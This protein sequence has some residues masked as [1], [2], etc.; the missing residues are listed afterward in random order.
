MLHCACDN[1]WQSMHPR[2]TQ[3]RAILVLPKSVFPQKKRKQ[4]MRIKIKCLNV[5]FWSSTTDGPKHI[6]SMIVDTPSHWNTTMFLKIL[7]RDL[8]NH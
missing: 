8:G 5:E 6:L 7:Q 3:Y 2:S 1:Q 4:G